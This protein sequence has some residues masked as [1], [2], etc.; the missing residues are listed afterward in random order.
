MDEQIVLDI[1]YIL[2]GAVISWLVSAIYYQKNA[3]D[4]T[5]LNKLLFHLLDASGTIEVKEWH[6]ETGLPKKWS[7]GNDLT[8]RFNTQ[9]STPGDR[10]W[11]GFRAL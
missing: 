1:L 6:P 8:L 7:V 5:E 9:A 4:L 3:K 2:L 10:S 11:T